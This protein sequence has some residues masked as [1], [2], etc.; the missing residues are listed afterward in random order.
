MRQAGLSLDDVDSDAIN[1]AATTMTVAGARR[2][3]L[4]SLRDVSGLWR[5]TASSVNSFV[6]REF[7][8][9]VGVS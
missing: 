5:L 8:H 7:G 4:V 2:V 1:S 6:L 9:Q 3:R